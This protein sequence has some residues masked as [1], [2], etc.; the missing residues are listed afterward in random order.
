MGG[1]VNKYTRA[2]HQNPC[3]CMPCARGCLLTTAPRGLVSCRVLGQV[4]PAT[5]EVMP[6]TREVFAA[7]RVAVRG[8][9]ES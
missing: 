8:G 4:L 1:K 3:R 7:T 6:A 5:L 2:V 9:L